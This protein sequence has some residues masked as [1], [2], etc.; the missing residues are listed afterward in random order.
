MNTLINFKS[1]NFEVNGTPFDYSGNYFFKRKGNNL[2]QMVSTFQPNYILVDNIEYTQSGIIA[3]NGVVV[4]LGSYLPAVLTIDVFV[5]HLNF[6]VFCG[7][8]D[9]YNKILDYMNN[10]LISVM[11]LPTEI[12]TVNKVTNIAIG[13]TLGTPI[14]GASTNGFYICKI[15]DIN[16]DGTD[17]CY[18]E[19]YVTSSFAMTFKKGAIFQMGANGSVGFRVWK[20]RTKATTVTTEFNINCQ[21]STIKG[22]L[23]V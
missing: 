15:L 23:I 19:D 11:G 8:S 14:S 7:A 20:D 21:I 5:A 1:I 6:M 12:L 18:G 4:N 10:G 16:N 9:I 13:Q 22:Y 17:I 3:Y 2:F